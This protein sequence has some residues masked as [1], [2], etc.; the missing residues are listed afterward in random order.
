M[1]QTVAAFL[2]AWQVTGDR[3]YLEKGENLLDY[4]LLYQQCWTNPVLKGMTGPAMLLGGFTTQNSD[5][6]WSDARQSQCGNIL[7][8]Y[9][10]AT[11]KAEYLERGVAALRAQFPIS[12]SE[13]WA[14]SGYGGKAGVSSFHWG[15]GSG[16]AGIE[17]EA[18]FLRDAIVDVV[19]KAAVGVNGLN[20]TKCEIDAGKIT[21]HIDSPFLWQ[22]EPVLVFR[23]VGSSGD[24][25]LT[26]NGIATGT[27]KAVELESGIAIPFRAASSVRA[28]DGVAAVSATDFLHSLGACTHIGQGI[29]NPSQSPAALAYAGWR[30]V[31]DEGSPRHLQDWL[32]Q[33]SD[34]TFELVVWSEKAEGTNRVMVDL[35]Q[36]IG[37]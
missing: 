1:S 27:Y 15:S 22:R 10:R 3:D 11:G 20:V 36:T 31:R 35:G 18:E 17:L 16:L 4:L 29:D 32:L 8:D 7:L 37:R 25:A 13:N 24:Y 6:E 5:A 30:N 34:G 33:K 26:V 14:H 9:Y 12:P 21:L 23:N 2:Q 19:S 28:D